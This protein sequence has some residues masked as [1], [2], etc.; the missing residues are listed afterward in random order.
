MKKIKIQGLIDGLNF[1][2]DQRVYSMGGC[3]PTLK[4]GNLRVQVIRKSNDGKGKEIMDKT[5]N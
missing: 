5:G 1:E 4:S 2:M 3:C